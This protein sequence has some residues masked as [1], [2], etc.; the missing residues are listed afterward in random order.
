MNENE[1]TETLC[2]SLRHLA[3]VIRITR[4][5]PEPESEVSRVL[6]PT[7]LNFGSENNYGLYT[8][9]PEDILLTQSHNNGQKKDVSKLIRL[10]ECLGA[11]VP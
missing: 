4:S 7:S 10:V 3:P 11:R 6:H 2:K 1:S 9:K 8:K 5:R